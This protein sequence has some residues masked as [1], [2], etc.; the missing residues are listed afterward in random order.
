MRSLIVVALGAA[1]S[2]SA[3]LS[4]WFVLEAEHSPWVEVVDGRLVRTSASESQVNAAVEATLA[5]ER[6]S[7][8]RR[9]T[10]NDSRFEQHA[11]AWFT[12]PDVLGQTRERARRLVREQLD[13][14]GQTLRVEQLSGPDMPSLVFIEHEAKGRDVAERLATFLESRGCRRL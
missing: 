3:S 8:D 9:A 2:M 10:L 11:D 14:T 7:D 6:S 4:V 12:Q 1:L 13:A 5:E